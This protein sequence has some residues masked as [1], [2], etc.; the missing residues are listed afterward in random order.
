MRFATSR[1]WC[2]GMVV[3]TMTSEE[4]RECDHLYLVDFNGIHWF[5]PQQGQFRFCPKC[6]KKLYEEV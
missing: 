4:R 1:T 2:F 6:G 3:H 5:T